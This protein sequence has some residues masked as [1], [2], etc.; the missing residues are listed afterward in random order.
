ME[1]AIAIATMQ[2]PDMLGALLGRLQELTFE[3]PEPSVE[4]IVVDNDPEQSAREVIESL[5][6]AGTRFPI[7]Y[8]A[9]P[10]RGIPFVRNTAVAAALEAGATHIAFIDDDEVPERDWLQTLLHV[11]KVYDADVVAG[12]CLS[13]L[14][15]DA[16]AWAKGN[17][18]RHESH[19]TGDPLETCATNNT[20]VRRAVFERLEPW[21]DERLAL[22]GGTDRHFFLRAHDAGMRL[23]WAA[24]AIV[25]EE[26][27]KSRVTLPWVITRMYRQGACNAFCEIDLERKPLARLQ[28][29]AQGAAFIAGGAVLAPLG[30][31][32]ALRP[33]QRGQRLVQYARY[34]AYG[35]GL[36]ATA[37][38][39]G[40][41]EEYKT[42]HGR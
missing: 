21:F 13:R 40:L 9:D 17:A 31:L 37:T 30:A 22:T 1:V 5:R 28:M 12:P 18:F 6:A 27:P 26:V 29:L 11:Q 19:R 8:L 10:R 24:E 25:R 14:P 41:Y 39:Q 23:C 16:P 32:S 7:R 20:L 15:G 3:Q 36:I 38:G 42:I 2:R 34:A 35:V 33:S 4:L